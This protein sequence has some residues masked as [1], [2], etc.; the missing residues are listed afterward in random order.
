MYEKLRYFLDNTGTE[1]RAI[2]KG[3][4]PVTIRPSDQSAAE[5]QLFEI[6]KRDDDHF[7]RFMENV[8]GATA[9]LDAAVNAKT[10]KAVPIAEIMDK[11]RRVVDQLRDAVISVRTRIPNDQG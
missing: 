1:L 5:R 6:L 11:C 10:D 3:G 2:T 7:G 8:V 9:Q 4:A